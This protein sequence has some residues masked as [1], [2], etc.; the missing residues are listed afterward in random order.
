MK[1]RGW[2]WY[3]RSLQSKLERARVIT[4][5]GGKRTKTTMNMHTGIHLVDSW[6][7]EAYVT[8]YEFCGIFYT[9]IFEQW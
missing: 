9:L 3:L 8:N 5:I 7:Y 6:I 2:A 1:A 4:R